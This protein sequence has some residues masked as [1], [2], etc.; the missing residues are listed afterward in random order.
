MSKALKKTLLALFTVTTLAFTA[1]GQSQGQGQGTATAAA[2]S[3]TSSTSASA[4]AG[5]ESAGLS[6]NTS[7]N[8]ELVGTVD[9]RKCQPGQE[10]T[11]KT[12]QD[13]KENG[14]VVLRKG[15]RLVGHVTQAQTRSKEN[16]ESSI[17]IAFDEAVMKDGTHVPFHAGIQALA[18]SQASAENAMY[19]GGG[20]GGMMG[21][22]GMA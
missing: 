20:G 4:S 6:S 19:S 17:G 13:V 11:A 16:A 3:A 1:A 14:R 7:V 2:A 5:P 12:T 8:A 22:G 9:A 21:G 18:E 15:T 10:I